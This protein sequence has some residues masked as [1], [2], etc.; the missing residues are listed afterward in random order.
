MWVEHIFSRN[1]TLT[2][3]TNAKTIEALESWVPKVSDED[4]GFLK[5]KMDADQSHQS[6]FPIIKDS[7][8]QA[9]I[10]ERLQLINTP[11]PTLR[12]FF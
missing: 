11:I 8:T 7:K 9:A 10:W 5:Q 1:I 2:T 3:H 4:L 6:L 12:T